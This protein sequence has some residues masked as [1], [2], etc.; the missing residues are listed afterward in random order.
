MTLWRYYMEIAFRYGNASQRKWGFVGRKFYTEL[1]NYLQKSLIFN[2][3]ISKA[4]GIKVVE[5]DTGHGIIELM[6][7]P[8]FTEMAT[9]SMEYAVD[10]IGIDPTFFDVMVMKNHDLQVRDINPG[11]SHTKNGKCLP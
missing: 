10:M 9:S 2:D 6:T 4:V 8:M 5:L 3:T 11:R 7:H 1:Y